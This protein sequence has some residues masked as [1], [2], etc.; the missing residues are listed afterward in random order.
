MSGSDS[1]DDF[2]YD[3][4]SEEISFFNSINGGCDIIEFMISN[5]YGVKQ[6]KYDTNGKIVV[7]PL[8]RDAS[9]FHINLIC[10]D[11]Q[12]VSFEEYLRHFVQFS[13]DKNMYKFRTKELYVHNM[14]DIFTK[15]INL[16]D[17]NLS[18]NF[19]KAYER[20]FKFY[21]SKN[22]KKIAMSNDDIVR[23]CF[24]II[25]IKIIGMEDA[26]NINKVY[27]IKHNMLYQTNPIHISEPKYQ[28]IEISL[29]DVFSRSYDSIYV[30]ICE[31]PG[32]C[33]I[34]LLY[35]EKKHYHC[36][37]YMGDMNAGEINVND[38]AN[39]IILIVI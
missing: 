31:S 10:I 3:I 25:K 19:F 30:D 23:P 36:N 39:T 29:K 11:T 34:N 33:H 20:G 15:R 38:L 8:Q 13:I 5:G 1:E 32:A 4:N 6:R 2:D 21:E 12:R 27:W 14:N 18:K 24:N 28:I 22:N 16:S 7:Y 17:F 9:I 35:P 26:I 37:Y